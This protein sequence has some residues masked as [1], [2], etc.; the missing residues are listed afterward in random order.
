MPYSVK[1]RI[2]RLLRN[3]AIQ[4]INWYALT[5]VLAQIVLEGGFVVLLGLLGFSPWT[6]LVAWILFHTAAWIFLYGGFMIVWKLFRFETDVSRLEAYR[7]RVAQNL[8]R[9]PSLRIALLRG[10]AARGELGTRSD[11]DF[12]GVPERTFRMKVR[13]ILYWWGLRAGAAL[14]RIPVEARWVD[15]ER[16]V[17]YHV[18]GE[19]PIVLKNNSAIRDL[20]RRLTSHGLLVVFSGIDGSG[21]TTSAQDLVSSLNSRGLRAVY[22]YGHRPAYL[23]GGAHVSFAI[24]FKSFWRRS[25]R[26]LPELE[27][28]R[29]AKLAFDIATLLDYIYV[30]W[31]LSH[32]LRPNT[33]VVSDRYVADVIA[34]LR[35]LGP[36]K[37]SLAGLLV[38]YSHEPDVAMFFDIRPEEALKRKQEQTPEE[39]DKF[40]RG[41][42][43]LR[44]ILGL[45]AIDASRSVSEVRMHVEQIM[46]KELQLPSPVAPGITGDTVQTP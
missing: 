17:P 32:V 18:S 33:I 34:Y 13:A 44:E 41:Y 35:F 45:A 40:A 15:T 43:D 6:I 3:W 31:K 4:S 5:E 28:H 10:S 8:R 19:S 29:R 21:K 38:R 14:R 26:A 22:F 23:R 20:R 30:Q 1:R 36:V 24:A 11:V 46:A 39:L 7:D 42:A 9:E 2:G 37:E 16:L 27:K 25:G 12:L